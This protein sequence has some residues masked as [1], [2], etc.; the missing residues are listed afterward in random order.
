MVK[1]LHHTDL[2][3]YQKLLLNTVL[4]QNKLI[5][6]ILIC[7]QNLQAWIQK[8][9]KE[10]VVDKNGVFPVLFLCIIFQFYL[11]IF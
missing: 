6:L 4:F 8:F 1:K 3:H 9:S 2:Y 10:R 5:D 11:V 7:Q